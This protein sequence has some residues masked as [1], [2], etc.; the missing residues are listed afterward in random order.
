M[1]GAGFEEFAVGS[2]RV[3]LGGRFRTWRAKTLFAVEM[4]KASMSTGNRFIVISV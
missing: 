4:R 2:E 3:G 1:G